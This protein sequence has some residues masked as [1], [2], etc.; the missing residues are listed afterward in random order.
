M[1]Q[2]TISTIFLMILAANGM[3]LSAQDTTNSVSITV[4]IDGLESD[5]GMLYLSLFDDE[6]NWLKNALHSAQSE[7]IEGRATIVF[8]NIEPG[9]YALSAYH[10]ENN[11]QK[12]DTGFMGIPKEPYASSNGAKGRF[13]P[14]KW[15]DAKLDINLDQYSTII[16]F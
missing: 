8:E 6:S 14:P 9:V 16:N 5:E 4:E 3:Q 7:I 10:D 2:I 12:L 11:N 15:K 13:G 1:K